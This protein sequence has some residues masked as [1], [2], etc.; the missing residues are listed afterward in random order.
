MLQNNIIEPSSSDWSCPCV[1]VP[2][3]D[4]TVHFC[5]NFRKLNALTKIDSFPLPRIEDC[6]ERIG[7]ARYMTKLDLLKGYWQIPL[8]DCVQAAYLPLLHQMA[9]ISIESCSLV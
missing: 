6:I 9:Y 4:G 1:L 2:K 5:T 8:T 7:K 3:L